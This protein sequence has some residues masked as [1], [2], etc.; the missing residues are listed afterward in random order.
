MM[1][2][3]PK[4][5]PKEQRDRAVRMLLDRLDDYPSMYAACN[6]I[7][8]KL[9]IGPETLRRWGWEDPIS[10]SRLFESF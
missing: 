6:A 8:P 5:Y 9:G 10:R 1:V 7:G 2:P 4:R 3:M